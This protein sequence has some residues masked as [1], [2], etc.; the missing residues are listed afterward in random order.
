MMKEKNEI[1]MSE[2]EYGMLMENQIPKP[3]R[4]NIEKMVKEGRPKE[5]QGKPATNICKET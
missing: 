2:K 5:E 3:L 1:T 4:K